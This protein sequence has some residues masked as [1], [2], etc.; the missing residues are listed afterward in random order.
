MSCG[1]LLFNDFVLRRRLGRGNNS[2]K[3]INS[4]GLVGRDSHE[5]W[6]ELPSLPLLICHFVNNDDRLPCRIL[7]MQKGSKGTRALDR[8]TKLIELWGR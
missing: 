5:D 1:V 2:G 8:T 3:E 4:V 6:I 7:N